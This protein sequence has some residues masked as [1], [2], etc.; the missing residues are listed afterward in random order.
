M[1]APTLPTKA[2]ELADLIGQDAALRVCAVVG[3]LRPSVPRLG[4]E[5]EKSKALF[6]TL[7]HAAGEAA[8]RR[9]FE[10]YAGGE[11]ELPKCEEWF[12]TQVRDAAILAGGQ[13]VD[14]LAK[15]AGLTRRRVFQIRAQAKASD[16]RN[17]DM[18]A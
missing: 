14:V 17:A 16:D 2:Q 4:G 6:A 12:R 10:H 3:G 15:Q 13:P 18:F 11:L 5:T 9:I 1:P 8:A 7:A